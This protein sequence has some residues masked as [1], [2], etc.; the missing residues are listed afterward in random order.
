MA[1][2]LWCQLAVKSTGYSERNG[3]WFSEGDFLVGQSVGHFPGASSLEEISL[4]EIKKAFGIGERPAQQG[5]MRSPSLVEV[6]YL[7]IAEKKS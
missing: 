6:I 7:D 2:R 5:R 3:A 1:R 4:D